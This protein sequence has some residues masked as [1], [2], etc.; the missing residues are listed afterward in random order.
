M[1]CIHCTC[2]TK[3]N[4]HAVEQGVACKSEGD[5]VETDTAEM[6]FQNSYGKQITTLATNSSV[7]SQ[8]MELYC[9]IAAMYVCNR[10][11]QISVQLTCCG[12]ITYICLIHASLSSPDRQ[13][14]NRTP[15][16]PSEFRTFETAHWQNVNSKQQNQTSGHIRAW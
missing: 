12:N 8:P 9:I 16:A 5:G 14:D 4:D 15:T 6:T 7:K 2:R 10:M 11:H 1:L 13:R 3:R